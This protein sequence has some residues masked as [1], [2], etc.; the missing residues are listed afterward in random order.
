MGMRFLKAV[1]FI[2]FVSCT[3]REKTVE[4][5]LASTSALDVTR[6]VNQLQG[7]EANGCSNFSPSVAYPK[8][9]KWGLCC[10]QHDI[11]YWKGGTNE[12]RYSADQRLQNC[13]IEVGEPNIA[14]LVY[15]GVRAKALTG[16]RDRSGE[17][18]D[19]GY[20][21]KLPRGYAPFSE[22][23]ILQIEKQE[24]QIST[25]FRDI[26]LVTARKKNQNTLTGNLCTDSALTFIQHNLSRKFTPLAAQEAVV[27][28]APGKFEHTVTLMSKE[29]HK[30]YVFTF[31][32]Q[33]RNSCV[34]KSTTA[35]TI[36]SIT[37]KE[38]DYPLECQ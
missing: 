5:Q 9:E 30:P 37:L 6:L 34:Y 28:T 32:L 20:G 27:E 35:P 25:E 7:F 19:W 17:N 2:F 15:W 16:E 21:W 1:V 11:A 18:W 22:A 12:D 23:E 13:I 14:R 36:P 3:S 29:C 26:P 33:R 8:K 38:F 4:R 31:E 24:K 10:V